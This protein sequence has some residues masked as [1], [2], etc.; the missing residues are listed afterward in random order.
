MLPRMAVPILAWAFCP[1]A[2]TDE[3]AS[4]KEP[5]R[6]VLAKAP[7]VRLRP[8]PPI[9]KE[10]AEHIKKL[11]AKLAEIEHPDVGYSPDSE[12]EV[13]SPIPDH[14][15]GYSWYV[16]KHGLPSSPSLCALVSIGPEALPFLLDALEDKTPTKLTIKYVGHGG[17]SDVVRE[18]ATWLSDEL[19]G[20]ELNPTE[21][22]VIDPRDHRLKKGEYI[23]SYRIKIG[24]L[25]FVAIGKIVGR[26]YVAVRYQMTG[27][28][29]INSPVENAEFRERIRK[30]WKSEN[31]TQTLFG[32]LWIDYR[33]IGLRYQYCAALRLL[34]YFPEESVPIIATR[35]R[36]LRV[37]NQ[38]E[39]TDEF[40][41]N[42]KANGGVCAD[43]FVHA[44]AWCRE[45][46]VREAVRDIFHRTG[47]VRI[48]A[49]ATEAFEPSEGKIIAAKADEIL[50][51]LNAA[52][53]EQG[54]VEFVLG[55]TAERAGADAVPLFRKTI[56]KATPSELGSIA[57]ALQEAKGNWPL[58]L[59]KPMLDDVRK[60]ERVY[61]VRDESVPVS[62]APLVAPPAPSLNEDDGYQKIP[63]RV[64]DAAAETLSKLLKSERGKFP[65]KHDRA[66]L[67]QFIARLKKVIPAK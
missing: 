21:T 51:G 56:D 5:P 49:A 19:S 20:N 3:P 38:G 63:V 1:L 44:A 2:F 64:C 18:G 15:E 25:C 62:P 50:R 23:D 30:I 46:A 39:G 27:C 47:D 37:H 55:V 16:T 31:P 11:I 52:E 58:P 40:A 4:K 34:Y 54:A 60:T 7:D 17:T 65:A 33:T 9:T 66:S 29:V 61:Y 14:V 10:K 32:S 6:I 48:F 26:P 8:R 53:R 59:L 36:G 41:R 45:L 43:E 24:D 22:R 13:S 35:L 57:K 67:D 12:R 28:T 42:V